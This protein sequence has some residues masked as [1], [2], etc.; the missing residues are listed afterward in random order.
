M[1]AG[2]K[3]SHRSSHTPDITSLVT[4]SAHPA[5]ASPKLL[6]TVQHPHK[7]TLL[8]SASCLKNII[9]LQ[10]GVK[11]HFTVI[12]NENLFLLIS[13]ALN[14]HTGW[15]KAPAMQAGLGEGSW[16]EI[17]SLGASSGKASQVSGAWRAK[18]NPP[19]LS[20]KPMGRGGLGQIPV[21][22]QGRLP[23]QCWEEEIT[24]DVHLSSIPCLGV[25]PWP[26]DLPHP[27]SRQVQPHI[28]VTPCPA[29]L[30]VPSLLS[31]DPSAS[32][33]PSGASQWLRSFL[34]S[35]L[36]ISWPGVGSVL[37]LLSQHNQLSLLCAPQQKNPVCAAGGNSPTNIPRMGLA[38]DSSPR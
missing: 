25:V 3:P 11:T 7:G 19:G 31:D 36:Q 28:P 35:W 8:Q 10:P 20:A 37:L 5:A 1:S 4:P 22:L 12:R 6:I 26:W 23:L 16:N 29:A 38:Q 18:R 14:T 24:A 17:K 32:P 21:S 9:P 13:Q 27:L 33:G 15:G 30:P 2:T 34:C